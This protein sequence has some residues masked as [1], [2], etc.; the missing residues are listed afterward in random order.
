ML[1]LLLLV[2]YASAQFVDTN[3]T[4]CDLLYQQKIWTEELL[5]KVNSDFLWGEL[6]EMRKIISQ[7]L[8]QMCTKVF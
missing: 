8:V 4:T 5:F 7:Q 1:L 2:V 6:D 3:E